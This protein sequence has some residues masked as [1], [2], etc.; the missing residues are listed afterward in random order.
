MAG[1]DKSRTPVRD[2]TGQAAFL[3]DPR[4]GPSAQVGWR[5]VKVLP[6]FSKGRYVP[7]GRCPAADRG[8]SREA[9]LGRS[10]PV[11]NAL[12]RPNR[13]VRPAPQGLG[14]ARGPGARWAPFRTDR[15]G[16]RDQPPP[17]HTSQKGGTDVPLLGWHRDRSRGYRPL[18]A[19]APFAARFHR[20]R[21]V[22]VKAARRCLALCKPLKRLER[23]FSLSLP[24]PSA[25]PYTMRNKGWLN[26]TTWPLPTQISATVP[27]TSAGIS[28]ISFMASMMHRVSPFF[29]WSPT[30]TKGRASGLGAE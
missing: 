14:V 1:L 12:R 19:C 30:S 10:L 28:F 24:Y 18:G 11:A 21:R 20:L 9:G 22:K 8:G 6:A 26:S 25:A 5:Q 4:A 27:S 15:G 17:S 29:T 2:R 23:N 13:Q 7:V 3:R 16:S